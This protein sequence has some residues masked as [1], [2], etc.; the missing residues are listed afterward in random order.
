MGWKEVVLEKLG[1]KSSPAQTSK[2]ADSGK[3][4][5]TEAQSSPQL[6]CPVTGMSFVWVPGGAFQMGDM[7]KEGN[8]DEYP[9]HA[10]AVEGFW[11]GK[12]PVTQYE[13]KQV[14]GNNPSLSKKGDLYPVECVTWDDVQQFIQVLNSK[15]EGRYR[16]PTE[17]EWEYAC[18]SGG[19]M[20]RYA[21]G[22]DVDKL[23]W[24]DENSMKTTQPVGSKLPNGLGIY[25]M[26][27]NVREWTCSDYGKYDDPEMH[28][29]R[30]SS[31]ATDTRVIR[32]GS[33]F[34]KSRYVRSAYRL[35]VAH[36]YLNNNIGFRLLM[37]P[38]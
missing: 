2:A 23:A 26:S 33:W 28:H 10:V 17:S 15:T 5:T 9:V 18:R 7:F 27:G 32:G 11:I 31:G 22:E 25:D 19:K 21:G 1:M 35:A 14:M 3:A 16:L 6:R 37:Q 13:W 30:C 8:S 20:E 34:N 24:Y 4:G 36:D 29:A 38:K 12:Y